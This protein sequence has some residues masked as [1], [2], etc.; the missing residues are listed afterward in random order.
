MKGD[1][2]LADLPAVPTG[3]VNGKSAPS[4]VSKRKMKT[5]EE[6]LKELKKGNLKPSQKAQ[7]TR[8]GTKLASLI[9][10]SNKLGKRAQ[11]IEKQIDALS[12]KILKEGDVCTLNSKSKK[13]KK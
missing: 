1:D 10:E 5:L 11:E 9:D 12:A 6:R 8:M 2:P 3:P 4:R 13:K 7:C